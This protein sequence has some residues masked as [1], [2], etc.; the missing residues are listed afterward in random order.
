MSF[1]PRLIDSLRVEIRQMKPRSILFKV[2]KEELKQLG[3]WRNRGR[4]DPAKGY[5]YAADKE[6]QKDT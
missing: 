5:R 2:L 4:G 1:N 3:Y 6:R